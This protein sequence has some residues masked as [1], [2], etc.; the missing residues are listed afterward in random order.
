MMIFW[1]MHRSAGKETSK[2]YT[3]IKMYVF[4]RKRHS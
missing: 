2:D 4:G 3:S 1:N